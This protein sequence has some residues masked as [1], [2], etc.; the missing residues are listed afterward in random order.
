MKFHYVYILQ[1]ESN[2]GRF[3]IGYTDD[4]QSR[5][6]SHNRKKCKHTS[7]YIPWKIKTA[8]AFTDE[9]KAMDFEKYLK[10]ASG[11]AFT[12]KRL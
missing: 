5:L 10:T 9:E 7:K 12:M 11:R 6:K 4:L 8:V 3:Y 1:S 2:S